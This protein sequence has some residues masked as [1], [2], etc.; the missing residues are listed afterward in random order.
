MGIKCPKCQHENPDDTLYCGKCATPLKLSEDISATKTLETQVEQLAPGSTFANRYEIIEELGKGGMGRVY[1]VHDAE[2]AEEVA[3]KL[4]K[5]EIASD[6]NTIE[7]FRNELKIARKVSHKNVCRMYDIGR[8]DEKY[9]ITMEYVAGEDLKS[10][11]RKKGNLSTEEAI[12]IAQQV[13]EGLAEA[14]RLG[15]VHRDLKPQNIMIDHEGQAKIMDFGIARSV[16]APGVTQTGVIIGT[17][18]YI[19]P[20]QAEGEKADQRSDIYSL[21][22]ILYEM[23]TGSVPFK[24]DTAFSV[25]LKHKTQ[26]PQDPRKFNSQL[27]D[28]LARLILVCMEKDRERRYQTAAD[29]LADLRNIEEG[30]PLG[31][32][33]RPR[34]K[35]LAATIAR[36]KAFIPALVAVIAIVA[37]LLWKF[38]P[39]GEAIT[40]PKIENSVAVISFENQTG[41][42]TYDY[43]SKVIPNLLI[44]GLEQAGGVYV[45]SWERLEDL[46][47]QLG[48]PEAKT[49]DKELGF[50]LCRL[51]G[52]ESIVLGSFVKAETTFV[53]DVKVLDVESKAILTSA[54]A[55]GEGEASILK[56]QID[57][58]RLSIA[59][60]LGL[61]KQ[62]MDLEKLRV[63]G[64]TTDSME[65]YRAYLEGV[66]GCTHSY[67]QEAAEDLEKAVAIDPRFASAYLTLSLAY[68]GLGRYSDGSKAIEKAYQNASKATE[69]ERLYIEAWY[70]Y[71]IEHNPQKFFDALQGLSQKYPKE[72][73]SY[74][75]SGWL[76]LQQGKN[77][78][79]V[80]MFQKTLALDPEDV[81]AHWQIAYAYMNLND[82]DQATRHLK[83]YISLN[84]G[85]ANPLN[86]LGD[87][88]LAMGK[89]DDAQ[90]YYSKAVALK[91]DFFL[92]YPRLAYIYA[93]KEDYP[94]ALDLLDRLLAEA[95]APGD[96]VEYHRC[97]G[98]YS[99]WLGRIDLC[100][101]H[102]QKAAEIS[103]AQGMGNIEDNFLKSLHYYKM[104]KL[105]VCREANDAWFSEAQRSWPD[106]Q[107][108]NQAWHEC[109]SALIDIRER[110]IQSAKTRL[111]DIQSFIPSMSDSDDKAWVQYIAD[112][113]EAEILLQEKKYDQALVIIG[114]GHRL[115][116]L[117]DFSSAYIILTNLLRND[118]KARILEEKG[119]LDRAISEYERLTKFDPKSD[120]HDLLIEPKFYYRLAG[121]YERK[122]LK[123]KARNTFRKFLTLW[124][125]ADPGLPEVEDARERLSGLKGN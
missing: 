16:E 118:V 97:K 34:R 84:P 102:L 5:P 83:K 30:F 91:P 101:S 79:S 36:K 75:Q 69:K 70:G 29:L 68:Y 38:L 86:S 32:K 100:L 64:V 67:Y 65:A 11:I 24:G 14:H 39:R 31:T 80:E 18:D 45:V 26:L 110:N 25:A 47:K 76:Y 81:S 90:A 46:L 23:V 105:D 33:I 115:P 8:E 51:E 52:V 114:E 99:F 21:G 1:K 44:S 104:D 2:I 95:S 17:P 96:K 119:D 98:F 85:E 35:T 117:K 63:S 6:E 111:A 120:D 108:S 41:D 56:S 12:G 58:L 50:R 112:L 57:E 37:V 74:Y 71:L 20:E 62:K 3:L 15:V 60:K 9:F 72:K 42:K 77:Q 89:L 94:K 22:V 13:C 87:V 10:L 113:L 123:A 122:G 124:K 66:E 125:D 40:A 103:A 4:L 82:Y 49:I 109:V 7:R 27:S 61:A 59:E 78:E 88:H 106:Y 92:P 116:F 54:S 93:L 28:D 53:T 19:S 73:D 121:L 48:R 107:K 55:R 43:L